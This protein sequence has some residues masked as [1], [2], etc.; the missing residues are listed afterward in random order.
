MSLALADAPAKRQRHLEGAHQVADRLGVSRDALYDLAHR[1][2]IFT[3][4]DPTKRGSRMLWTADQERGLVDWMTDQTRRQD[5]QPDRSP[6]D[7]F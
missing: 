3:R 6:S 1:S 4:Q 5:H 7:P 2:G